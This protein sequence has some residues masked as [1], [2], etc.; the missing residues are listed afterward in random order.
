[1]CGI[2]GF[3]DL[4]DR[5]RTDGG[6]IHRMIN[7]LAHRGPDDTGVFVRDNVSLGFT[8]L[9]IIDLA[10]GHQPLQ[11]EDNSITLICNGEIFNYKEL[12]DELTARGHVFKTGCDV[13]VIIHLYE[14][15]GKDFMDNLNGQFAFAL[16]DSVKRQLLCA[17]DHAGIAPFFYTVSNDI[18]IFASEI[19]AVLQHEDVTRNVDLTGLD[20]I[21][22]FPGMVSPRTLFQG[23]RS[24][25]GGHYLTVGCEDGVKN[26]E[27]WDLKYPVDGEIEYVKDEN[28]YIEK[29]DDLL[30]KAVSYRLQAD[31]PVGFYISGGIDSSVIA[32]KIHSL[33]EGI[34][35]QSFSINFTDKDISEAKYQRLMAEKI[36]SDHNELLFLFSDIGRRLRKAVYHSECAL[37]ET[38]NTASLALSESVRKNNIKVVLTGEGADELFGGYVGYR[39]DQMRQSRPALLNEEVKRENEL[40]ERLWGDERFLY[41]KNHY[42][43]HRTVR[44][45]YSHEVNAVYDDISCFNHPVINKERIKGINVFHQ[46]S[47]IDFKLRMSDHLL[48]DHGDRMA[49]ANSV[50]ARYPFLD[51]NI[52]EFART[53][54]V[55]VKLKDYKEKYILK[56]VAERIIPDEIVKRPKF[57]FVAPGSPELLKEANGFIDDILSYERIKRQGF[58]NPDTVERLKKQY[59]EDGFKLNVPYDNDFL[60]IVI[61]FGI[62]LEEFKM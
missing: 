32:A 31:V 28:Y 4:K 40:R 18:F 62:L 8:R 3:F 26:T 59:T 45:L 53:A 23:I 30:T 7:T 48:S 9:S 42:S 17:R 51:K 13:E 11:N 37:K 41:E 20:Q 5:N 25:E 36:N 38:Y 55:S 6:T 27:Y 19:K 61:T 10:G 24:L 58:F 2:C 33:G 44:D 54:P 12:R 60:I 21:M 35:R 22:N 50:E 52:I 14:D 39:F 57:A 43:Y 34:R 16:Y 49:F 15:Y 46:R 47:Y 56:R 29:L 1:M